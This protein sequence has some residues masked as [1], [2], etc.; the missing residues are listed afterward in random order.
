MRTDDI[1]GL[2]WKWLWTLTFHKICVIS[3]L[4]EK[5]SANSEGLGSIHFTSYLI[6]IFFFFPIINKYFLMAKRS[7]L[8]RCPTYIS[9]NRVSSVRY[10][11]YSVVCYIPSHVPGSWCFSEALCKWITGNLQPG[12]LGENKK[13]HCKDTLCYFTIFRLYLFHLPLS[14]HVPACV[15]LSANKTPNFLMLHWSVY[16]INAEILLLFWLIIVQLRA[17]NP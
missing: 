1:G 8:S 6:C 15:M 12:D 4:S 17:F 13:L 5:L 11:K 3:W 2:L 14:R 7:V 10:T 9:K 16:I